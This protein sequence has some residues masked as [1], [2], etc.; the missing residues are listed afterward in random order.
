MP[1]EKKKKKLLVIY[2]TDNRKVVPSHFIHTGFVKWS[3]N[4]F[5]SNSS[6]FKDMINFG[7]PTL[8]FFWEKLEF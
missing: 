1:D 4:F 2:V 6:V 7:K 3:K 8:N 5:M